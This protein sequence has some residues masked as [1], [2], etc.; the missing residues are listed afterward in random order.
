MGGIHRYGTLILACSSWVGAIGVPCSAFGQDLL[1]D[2]IMLSEFHL[3]L[4][5]YVTLPS[6][7]NNIISMITRPGDSRLYVTTQETIIYTVDGG[8]HGAATASPWF[9][10]GSAVQIATGRSIFGRSGQQGLQSVAFHPNF[11]HETT[12]GYGK[13]YT[14][15]I[16][17]RP[18]SP[19]GHFYLGNSTVGS[20]VTSDG[21]LV[22]WTFD[23]TTGE[24]DPASYRELFRVTMPVFDHPIK[25]AKFNPYAKPSDEDYGLLYLTHGDANSKDSPAD[26]PLHLDNSMGVMFRIDPLPVGDNRYTIP[27]SNPFADS[28]DPNVLKEI[29]AYGFRN[30][31]TYSFNRD[32]EGNVHILVG[33][34][35]RN[36][37][38][39]INL[40]VSGGNFGWTD[41]EGT[42]VHLQIPEWH[43]NSGYITGVDDLSANEAELGYIFPAAQY[44][45]GPAVAGQARTGNAIASGHVIQNGTDP[46]LHNQ[47]I[48]SDFG[49]HDGNVY[50]VD[51]AEMLAAVIQLD[52]DDPTRDEPHELTQATIHQLQLALDHDNNPATDPQIFDNFLDLLNQSR[53]DVR[54]GE[55]VFG[56]MY[57]SSKRNGTVYLVTNSV[58]LS[59]DTNRNGAVDA[60]DYT[61]WRDGL[62][63]RGFRLPADGNGDGFVGLHD[64]GVWKTHFGQ[65]AASGSSEPVPEP[66]TLLLALFALLAPLA[67]VGVPPRVRCE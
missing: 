37:I 5:P 18:S 21:V 49:G 24:V 53:T 2:N 43:A 26:D 56:E 63:E 13:L 7:T 66:A 3:E 47:L 14:S 19:D 28:E 4:R 32:N 48:L 22:E 1:N 27:T 8:P 61:L 62:G 42:F 51:F 64:Y 39:E 20:N 17:T 59:G 46:N 34:I 38:E 33:D 12:P 54:F 30:P 45:H 9:N 11:N 50:H 16:E 35:G 44:D 55:G 57:I 60:A 67:V 10:V 23:H 58:P 41:R 40:I 6:N 65:S 25:Q 29:Y 15:L 31:H 36:N 52:P